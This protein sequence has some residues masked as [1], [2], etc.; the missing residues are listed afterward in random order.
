M[1]RVKIEILNWEKFNPKRDQ[2]TYTW[3]RLSNTIAYDPELFGLDAEQRYV[4]ICILCQ[5]STDNKG[6]LTINL[7]HLADLTKVKKAKIVELIIFL[8]EKPI[9]QVHDRALPPELPQTTPTYERTNDTND[10]NE[11]TNVYTSDQG[12]TRKGLPEL[13]RI[14]NEESKH[15]PKVLSC[16]PSSPRRKLADNRWRE[17]PDEAYWRDVF[18]RIHESEFLTGKSKNSTWRA[19]FDWVVRPDSATKILEGK[20][21][22]Q[23]PQGGVKP[24]EMQQLREIYEKAHA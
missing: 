23:L 15:L 19:S 7:D 9:I 20:Y 21:S 22:N 2:S 4:W 24:D 8:Q 16:N 3:L 12:L 10:T 13:A 11:R 6:T 5:A 1:D 14:W 17:N 18:R